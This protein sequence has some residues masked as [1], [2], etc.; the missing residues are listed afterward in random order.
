MKR[1]RIG[2]EVDHYPIMRRD[3]GAL[4]DLFAH[5]YAERER[6]RALRLR[7]ADPST[8]LERPDGYEKDDK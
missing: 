7:P 2:R 4:G 6:E 1:R 3:A 5:A 8:A